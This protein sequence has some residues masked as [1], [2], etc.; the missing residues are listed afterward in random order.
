MSE[1]RPGLNSAVV[2]NRVRELGRAATVTIVSEDPDSQ[3]QQR[4]LGRA[5][6]FVHMAD[7]GQIPRET[8]VEI[9]PLLLAGR[10]MDFAARLKDFSTRRLTPAVVEDFAKM[11]GIGPRSLLTHILPVLKDA[12]VLDYT[13]EDATLA[14]VEEY[15][16]V[17][18]TLVEQAYRV[19]TQLAPT[20]AE[21]ALLHSV[22]LAS[23]APLTE[24]QHL[25]ELVRRG[26]G[27]SIASHGYHLAL[28]VGVNARVASS[29]L[30]EDVAFNPYVWGSGQVS[31]AKFLRSL[32]SAERDV[33]L[34]LC[35][36][37]SD[38]PGLALP[39]L[40]ASPQALTSARKVGLIQATTVKSSAAGG[41]SQTYVFSP[42]LETE[43]DRARTTEA[44][45]QRKLFVAH[46]LFGVE[47]ARSGYGRITHPTVLVRKLYERGS[48][49]PATNIGTDYHLLE[50]QGIVSV[51]PGYGDRAFLRMVK[52][53]IVR[54]GLD[55]LERTGGAGTDSG[56]SPRL[57]RSPSE[58][59]TPEQDRAALSDQ[60][61]T[62]EVARS[63]VLRLR[64]EVQS[65]TRQDSVL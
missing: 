56:V 55:W 64:E 35:E 60:G 43:D 23:W 20:A 31:I 62:D 2:S 7:A 58:F 57:L 38:R 12:D 41:S 28:S 24:S 37:A 59:V 5:V 54:D 22:E 47:K 46:I 65:A 32:P 50:A 33:M 14:G 53:E 51:D 18:G 52:P 16:G 6:A 40:Q 10:A 42:L 21:L 15:V 36:Q 49:G 48:V 1:P 11:A 25:H 17:T 39:A 13:V 3:Q 27:D 61:A 44:L 34:R 63:M 30:G 26:F 9:E 29:D 19:L 4:R 45:H 8:A